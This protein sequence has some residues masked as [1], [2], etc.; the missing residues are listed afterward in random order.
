MLG[1]MTLI[2]AFSLVDRAVLAIVMQ[3]IKT[4]L[5]LSDTQLGLMGGLAFAL[6]YA[7]MGIPLARWADRGNRKN[8]VA[9]TTTMWSVMVVLS[10]MATNFIQLLTARIGVAVGEAGCMP[11][12][13]SLIPEYFD[14]DERPRAMSIYLLGAPI[15]TIIGYYGGGWL[16]GIVGWRMTFVVLGAPGI[17]LGAIAWFTLKEPRQI[18]AKKVQAV[19]AAK[20]AAAPSIG[21]NEVI[22]IKDVVKFLWKNKSFK[23]LVLGFSISAFFGAGIGMWLP[24]FFIRSHNMSTVELGFWMAVLFGGMGGIGT[25]AGGYL[26]SRYAA[27]DEPRQFRWIAG[28]I[29]VSSLLSVMTYLVSGTYLALGLLACF[30]FAGGTI[31]APVFAAIQ[32]LVPD[33]MRSQAFAVILLFNS[34]I[35]LGFGP[36]AIGILSDILERYVGDQS[37]RYSL[38]LFSPGYLWAAYYFWRASRTV[39]SDLAFRI[40]S[41]PSDE[42]HHVVS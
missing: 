23:Q 6:F 33:N 30:A 34:I 35:G 8:I 41:S 1:L 26:C 20:L 7:V 39:E 11:L 29:C 5:S 12:A 14:R 40:E 13:N 19:T 37:L 38:V 9:L 16:S 15:S 25:F 28:L 27:N 21:Y 42:T 3:D 17:L 36:L 18:F 4:D 32:S 31:V 22:P 2:L 24:S 10:G